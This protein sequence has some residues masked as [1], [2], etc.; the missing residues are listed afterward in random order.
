[1]SEPMTSVEI[2]DVLSSIRR[3]VSEDM[4]PVARPAHAPVEKLILTPALRVV[5]G[6]D[7]VR[8]KAHAD[9]RALAEAVESAPEFHTLLRSLVR[10]AEP[11]SG[12]SSS[13]G[14]V[15]EALGASVPAQD[16]EWEPESGDTLPGAGRIGSNAW[17]AEDWPEQADAVSGA[18]D[19]AGPDA[20]AIRQYAD[21]A[22][23]EAVAEIQRHP[24]EPTATERPAGPPASAL[25]EDTLREMVRA[26]LR[27][28]LQG[29][30]GE[31]ITR[32]V[33]KL[34]RAEI[35]RM[36]LTREFD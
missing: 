22:E 36:M 9:L 29:A 11:V 17:A 28:E 26:L 1:M 10:P 31:R 13:V 35:Q 33:R 27:Q 18:A 15:V 20:D 8:E 25:D 12:L 30:L 32:N 7:A 16:P 34:V 6:D 24:P 3:L 21:A 19:P 23:A 2:E 5:P 4:R 14:A